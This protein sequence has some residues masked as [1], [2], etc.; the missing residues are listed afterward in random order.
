[1]TSNHFFNISLRCYAVIT[2]GKFPETPDS[3]LGP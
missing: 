2:K 1:M 3:S